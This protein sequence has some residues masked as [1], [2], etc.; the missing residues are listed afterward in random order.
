MKKLFFQGITLLS[1]FFI[2]WLSLAQIQWTNIFKLEKSG[3]ELEE[4]LGEKLWEV[5]SQEGREVLNDTI[6]QSLDSIIHTICQA[7]KID[8]ESIKL[9]VL[10]KDEI[11]A[12]A[13]PDGHL[14]VNTGLIKAVDRQEE[15]TGVIGHE[16]AH[17]ELNH[18]MKKLAK[19]VGISMLI[20]VSTGNNNGLSEIAKSLSSSAFDRS[21]EQAADIKAAEYLSKANVSPEHLANFLYKMSLDTPEFL[22]YL[23]WIN[24]HP[25]S[26]ERAEKILNFQEKN[27]IVNEPILSEKSWEEIKNIV[28]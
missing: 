8:E 6:V 19:E 15:L 1:L 17:I 16:I 26:Q 22:T 5:Y 4:K 3:K 14:V 27:L 2:C 7:N 20:S 13:L 11:N 24:T 21:Q 12:Y 28:K 10:E 9:H 18:V 23:T 25:D